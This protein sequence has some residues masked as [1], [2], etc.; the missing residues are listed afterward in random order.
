MS[1]GHITAPS[2]LY[3]SW[4]DNRLTWEPADYGGITYIA[5]PKNVCWIPD[6]ILV[7]GSGNEN[8]K[9]GQIYSPAWLKDNGVVDMITGE[10][11]VST[12]TTDSNW[13]PFDSQTCQFRI[14]STMYDTSE[15]ILTPTIDVINTGF[16]TN[17]KE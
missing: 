11:F 8:T 5:I 2:F 13:Y 14:G 10:Y 3:I 7:T 17:N 15:L 4:L 6:L 12:C 16:Y 1:T 9:I